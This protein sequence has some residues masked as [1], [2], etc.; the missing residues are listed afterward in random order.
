MKHFV[1]IVLFLLAAVSAAAET[2]VIEIPDAYV[3]A[4]VESAVAEGDYT[5]NALDGESELDFAKRMIVKAIVKRHV[6]IQQD[7][8]R[9]AKIAELEAEKAAISSSE[10][11]LIGTIQILATE[12]SM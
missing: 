12:G 9:K 3:P 5:A 1:F 2:V 7:K 4:L 10:A 6:E 11:V 8:A